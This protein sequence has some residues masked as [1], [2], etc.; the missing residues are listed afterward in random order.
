VRSGRVFRPDG[1]A[2]RL[3]MTMEAR[4]NRLSGKL[5]NLLIRGVL[6]KALENDIDLVKAFCNGS[7][8]RRSSD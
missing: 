2:T 5:I 7:S 6:K 8:V 4:T 3:T 1:A